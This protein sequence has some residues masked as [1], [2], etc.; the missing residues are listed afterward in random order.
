[1]TP[2]PLVDKA[3]SGLP[4]AFNAPKKSGH[5][6][7]SFEVRAKGNLASVVAF[8]ESLQRTPLMHRVK[9]Y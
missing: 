6:V 4:T 9:Q 8:L 3:A 2:A 5:T 7:L 1:M